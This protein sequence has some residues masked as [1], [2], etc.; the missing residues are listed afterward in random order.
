MINY[1]ATATFGLEACVKR[2]VI[3]LGFENVRTFDGRVEFTGDESAI[4]RANLWLRCAGR[5]FVKMGEFKATSFEELFQG[6]KALPWGDWIPVD[7]KFTVVGKSVKSTLH[8]VPD[9]Q[10]IVKKAIVEKL[11][12]K[13]DVDWFDETGAEYTVQVAL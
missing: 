2:E 13:Y 8:S 9:C 4:P 1:I 12:E 5:V 3:K 6:T 11:K 10:A 7:G